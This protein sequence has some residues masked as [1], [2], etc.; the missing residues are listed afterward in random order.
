MKSS[1][2]QPDESEDSLPSPGMHHKDRNFN[3]AHEGG[4]EIPSDVPAF[5]DIVKIIFNI[6]WAILYALPILL[7]VYVGTKFGPTL[8]DHF[9]L[10][11]H[12][13][14]VVPL[15]VPPQISTVQE[16]IVPTLVSSAESTVETSQSMRPWYARD[17]VI[18][19]LRDEIHGVKSQIRL[20]S[21]EVRKLESLESASHRPNFFSPNLGAMV[22]PSYT[23]PTNARGTT[24]L[25][26]TWNSLLSYIPGPWKPLPPPSTA[27]L[28]WRE[29]GDCWCASASP[30]GA[31]SLGIRLHEP[32]YPGTFVIDHI[33]KQFALNIT[34]APKKLDLWGH[35]S[36]KTNMNDLPDE[37]RENQKQCESASPKGKGWVCLGKMFYNIDDSSSAQS[38][39][40]A[41]YDGYPP[42]KIDIAVLRVL[43]NYGQEYTCLYQVKLEGW[44]SDGNSK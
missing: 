28:P 36:P 24:S 21:E 11:S 5:L 26:R 23:T 10:S 29:N 22:Y 41:G 13:S 34:S 1:S 16:A 12:S 42:F 33:S 38:L 9:P 27:L 30:Q 37:W 3:E 43:E 2:P 39:S 32:V 31:L 18:D 8:F 4:L 17:R 35:V 15:P 40:L 20:V 44:P 14:V 25:S 6:I 7:L 19:D